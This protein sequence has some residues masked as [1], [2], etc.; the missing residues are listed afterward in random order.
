MAKYHKYVFDNEARRLVGDFE[1]M[2][3]AEDSEGFDSWCSHDARH[4]R[5]RLSLA[6]LA[7]YNFN[8]VLEVGCGKGTVA[9]FLKRANNQVI[10]IDISET[11]IAKARASFPDID[12]RCMDALDIG[13]LSE[14]FDLT[15]IQ[16]A[17]AYIPAWR[18]L[19]RIASGMTDY[20]L[21]A[22]YIPADPIGMVKSSAEL[23]ETF[24]SSFHIERKLIVD[25]NVTILF[26]RSRLA[27]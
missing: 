24:A 26:G 14:R 8:K 9:Q 4:L 5:I 20:C 13:G 22:E 23:V 15:A 10:G 6:I 18:D 12:F 1:A 25:D 27:R 17:L 19:I 11:A 2:Y 16:A 3:A 7:E 21:V